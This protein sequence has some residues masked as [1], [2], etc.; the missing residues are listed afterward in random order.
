MW[1]YATGFLFLFLACFPCVW[2]ALAYQA[3][4]G[5]FLFFFLRHYFLLA[6]AQ[7]QVYSMLQSKLLAPLKKQ[8]PA[9]AVQ[10]ERRLHDLHRDV[11]NKTLPEGVLLLF[12]FLGFH[13]E[14]DF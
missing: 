11:V 8:Q 4:A 2:R 13:F 1:E 12:A 10:Q 6:S 9:L 7:D 5:G 3:T 14:G